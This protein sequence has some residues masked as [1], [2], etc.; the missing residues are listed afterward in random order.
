M[1]G[2]RPRGLFVLAAGLLT[3]W[4]AA[5]EAQPD[6]RPVRIGVINAAWAASHPT[7]EGLKAGLDE[8][9]FREGRD[10]TFDVR[11]TEGKLVALPAAAQALVKARVDLIFTSQEA[12][13]QAAKDATDSIPVVFTLVN[14][15]V[16]AGFVRTLNT[17]RDSQ[18]DKFIEANM[19][20]SKPAPGEDG[21]TF[22][23]R[24]GAR[25][26]SLESKG[27]V[28]LTNG[29]DAAAF[30]GLK[31]FFDE[32]AGNCATC[33]T[34]PLFTDFSFHNK[35]V[36]QIDYDRAHSE[37]KFAALPATVVRCMRRT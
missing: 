9:G 17:R 16:G 20:E 12:P 25:I 2:L 31:L 33:H 22:A 34:P 3:V 24:L 21:K 7:V 8:L 29:F 35:G 36:S 4:L 37:G 32:R 18:Y 23:R 27:A 10:V 13:T 30:K 5:A 6:R 19:L 28:R 14:D 11:F 15:P 26:D 1:R